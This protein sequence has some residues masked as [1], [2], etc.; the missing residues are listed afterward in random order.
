MSETKKKVEANMVRTESNSTTNMP[1]AAG[2]GAIV[3][4]ATQ[5]SQ[6][7]QNAANRARASMGVGAT[8]APTISSFWKS[9]QPDTEA[10]I[11]SIPGFDMAHESRDYTKNIG[12]A[13][14]PNTQEVKS[15]GEQKTFTSGGGLTQQYHA[16]ISKIFDKL[17]QAGVSSDPATV[18]TVLKTWFQP[19]N[20]R[21]NLGEGI[22]TDPAFYEVAGQGAGGGSTKLDNTVNAI[23]DFYSTTKKQRDSR[24][25]VTPT[26]TTRTVEAVVVPPASRPRVRVAKK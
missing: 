26:T 23:A 20:R 19:Q 17:E 15:T 24:F 18:R 1:A 3:K 8:Q 4:A 22:F 14:Q 25:N 12:T 9:Q 16:G 6:A 7:S 13:T 10:A 2:T 21:A 11:M 5:M